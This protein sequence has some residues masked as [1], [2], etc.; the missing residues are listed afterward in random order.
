MCLKGTNL[1]A[2]GRDAAGH[3]QFPEG[4]DRTNWPIQTDLL[5]RGLSRGLP[6]RPREPQAH[7]QWS[8]GNKFVRAL[9]FAVFS[10]PSIVVHTFILYWPHSFYIVYLWC[11]AWQLLYFP[12]LVLFE[13]KAWHLRSCRKSYLP[14]YWDECWGLEQAHHSVL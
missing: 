1:Y 13:M 2:H 12:R 3:E 10:L 4:Y 14:A 8:D 5:V 9:C 7:S 11:P 6:T